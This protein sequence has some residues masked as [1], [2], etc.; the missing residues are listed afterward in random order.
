MTEKEKLA[1]IY[2]L[3]ISGKAEISMLSKQEITLLLKL[4]N[5]VKKYKKD[6][7]PGALKIAV[8]G[9]YSIQHFTSVLDAFLTGV[10]FDTEIYEGEYDGIQMDVL[11]KESAFYRFKPQIVIMLMDERDIKQSPEYFSD[12]D[13]IRSVVNAQL[14]MFKALWDNINNN[15]PGCQILQSN[16]VIP[17]VRALGNLEAGYGFSRHDFLRRINH[18]LAV[19]HP[20]YVTIVDMEYMASYV[21]KKS[22]FDYSSYF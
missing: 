10:G 8:L 21:G 4:A 3:V 7:E 1:S 14:S 22:W 5:R 12:E 18:E 19:D 20:S 15:I 13:K 6:K 11:D 16:I 9:S 2:E 17:P